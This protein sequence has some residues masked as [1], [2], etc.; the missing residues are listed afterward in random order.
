MRYV[1]VLQCHSDKCQNPPSIKS[2]SHVK[3]GKE[4]INKDKSSDDCQSS[5]DYQT[6]KNSLDKSSDDYQVA[7]ATHGLTHWLIYEFFIHIF[8]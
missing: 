8:D 6:S 4:I 2:P 3:L 5:D 1:Y 7:K